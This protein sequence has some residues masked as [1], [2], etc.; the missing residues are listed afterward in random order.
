LL[1]SAYL[2]T[3]RLD[4]I[5]KVYQLHKNLRLA[6]RW[7]CKECLGKPPLNFSGIVALHFSCF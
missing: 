2:Q 6:V 4:P 1:P 3:Q 7:M 5:T